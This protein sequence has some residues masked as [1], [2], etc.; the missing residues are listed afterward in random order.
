M[1]KNKETVIHFT[2]I[3]GDFEIH[4]PKATVHN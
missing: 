1:S 3:D 2:T 4:L